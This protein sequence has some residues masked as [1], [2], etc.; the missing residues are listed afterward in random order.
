MAKRTVSQ[1]RLAVIRRT[2]AAI[3]RLEGVIDGVLDPQA[4]DPDWCM[5]EALKD[6]RRAQKR[7][8]PWATQCS[9][10]N[11]S[12]ATPVK[13]QNCWEGVLMCAKCKGNYDVE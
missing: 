11:K 5:A 1:D 12:Q 4:A 3:E 7:M 2:R 6:L 13:T 8:G 9:R 10:C